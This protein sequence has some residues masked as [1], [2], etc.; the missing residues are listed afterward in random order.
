MSKHTP[1]PWAEDKFAL[2][3]EIR[4]LGNPLIAVVQSRHCESP[5]EMAANAKLIAAAPML[6]DALKHIMKMQTFGYIVLGEEATTKA[7]AA[8]AAAQEGK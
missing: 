5:E 1:G 6:L 4:S 8:I 3:V 2:S 7:R